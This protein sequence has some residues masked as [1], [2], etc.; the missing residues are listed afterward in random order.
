MEKINKPVE[1][2]Q[3]LPLIAVRNVV[4]FPSV[5]TTLFVGRPISKR[6]LV[7][8]FDQSERLVLVVSQKKAKTER[9]TT[10]DLY[11]MGVVSKI[12]HI[13]QS[14]GHI[15]AVIRGLYRGV[16]RQIEEKAKVKIAKYIAELSEEEKSQ[17]FDALGY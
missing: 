17:I 10:S 12:E 5:E 14:D 13:L 4:M 8:S 15:H 16:I 3:K 6:A 9:P 1:K 2:T 11:Q 7:Y